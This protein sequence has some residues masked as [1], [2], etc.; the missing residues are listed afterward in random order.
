MS[1]LKYIFGLF[2][3]LF[4]KPKYEYIPY[5]DIIINGHVL[6]RI[7]AVR[8]MPE[9]GVKKGDPGGFIEWDFNLSHRNQ[10]WVYGNA[11]VYACARVSGNAYLYQYAEA[12]D[13]ARIFEDADVS[14][15]AKVYG[16]AK[17]NG[18]VSIFDHAEVFDN[19]QICESALVFRN[20]KV[21]GN[22]IIG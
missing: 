14:G 21:S 16:H 20:T 18:F 3:R 13:R 12:Y 17:V 11:R 7:R 15:C 9:I 5:S 2:I 22:T 1:V 8:D 19:A 4:V 6:R 10:C